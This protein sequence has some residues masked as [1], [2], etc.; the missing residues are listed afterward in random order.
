MIDVKDKKDCCGCYACAQICPK[1]CIELIADNEG[2]S[3][4]KVDRDVCI[5]CGLCERVCP[6]INQRDCRE[7]LAIYA[8]KHTNHETRMNSS[9]GG[10]FS[11]LAEHVLTEGG[12]V[13]GAKYDEEFNVVHGYTE[14]IQELK[15]FQGSKYVQSFIGDTF[16]HAKQFLVDGRKVLFA[17]TPCQIAGLKNFLQKEYDNLLTLDIICHGVPSPAVWQKYKDELK[18][19]EG[20]V[21]LKKVNFRDKTRGWDNYSCSYTIGYENDEET[22]SINHHKD[23]Y[24]RLFIANYS[25]RPSCYNCPAKAGRS[26]SDITLGDCWG[27]KRIEK[28]FD[29][30]KG[31]GVCVINKENYLKDII[32]H[33]SRNLLLPYDYLQQ[34]NRSY[35]RSSIRPVRRQEFFEK[36]EH[37]DSITLSAQEFVPIKGFVLNFCEKMIGFVKRRI[38]R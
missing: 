8:T 23:P 17:G 36:L 31:V 33:N 27:I 3:Y 7:P 25:L 18:E 1:Q 2:F 30:N 12:V 37:F 5:D 32:L 15:M 9:S 10:V 21:S 6:V 20:I 4:P 13:F 11:L 24:M 35:Y 28:T 26:G 38:R 14:K 29:D 16:S 34:H 22:V 19:G